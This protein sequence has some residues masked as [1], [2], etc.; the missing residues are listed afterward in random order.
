MMKNVAGLSITEDMG[1]DPNRDF[2]V[3][4]NVETKF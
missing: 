3:Q 1:F 4:E 2:R